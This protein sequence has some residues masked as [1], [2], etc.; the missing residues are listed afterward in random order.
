MG[1]WVTLHR[2]GGRSSRTSSGWGTNFLDNLWIEVNDDPYDNGVVGKHVIYNME[3]RQRVKIV[4]YVGSKK[5]ERTKVDEKLKEAGSRSAS[6]RS[7]IEGVIRRVKGIVQEH[8]GR[9]GHQFAEITHGR[10]LPGGPKL[11]TWTFN[12][13]TRARGQDRTVDLRR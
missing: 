4:D 9:E 13:K 12:V 2:R 10:R 5:V 11:V 8:D 1:V 3:E 7:S 6:T